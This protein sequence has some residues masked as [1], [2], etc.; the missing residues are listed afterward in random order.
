MIIQMRR[1]KWCWDVFLWMGYNVGRRKNDGSEHSYESEGMIS[2]SK[3]ESE[4]A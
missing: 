1:T 2:F 4:N 3:S